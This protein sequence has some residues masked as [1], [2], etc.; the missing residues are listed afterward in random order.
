M[1]IDIDM[2]S[3]FDA[4][5]VFD[6]IVPASMVQNKQLK[7]HPCGVYFQNVPKETLTG[8][9]AIPYD[10][11][12]AYGFFKIDFLHNSVYDFFESRSE[13]EELLKIDPD[14]NL[15]QIPSV[16]EK[17]PQIAKHISVLQK[18]KPRSILELADVLAL[19]R[20]GK[21][22]LIEK[23]NNNKDYIRKNYLYKSDTEN[24]SFKKAHAIAYAQMIV[25]CLHLVGAGVIIS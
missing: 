17:L 23:Y 13:I 4:G 22:F 10:K 15:L 12:E 6:D 18:T 1:D 3:S 20:P 8:L 19:I 24:Y 9:S 25:L 14:W 16:V 21:S 2:K 11:A 7:K 5:S